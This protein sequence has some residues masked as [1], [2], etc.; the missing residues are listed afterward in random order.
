M[1]RARSSAVCKGRCGRWAR[2]MEKGQW[3]RFRNIGHGFMNDEGM[4]ETLGEVLSLCCSLY[5]V[6][7]ADRTN[8]E[9]G[10]DWTRCCTH[11]FQ[12]APSAV[13]LE[14]EFHPNE[15]QSPLASYTYFL[16]RHDTHNILIRYN[17]PQPHS[18]RHMPRTCPPHQRIFECLLERPMH[19]ITHILN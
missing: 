5:L 8:G 13:T 18:L 2:A 1:V 4:N 12:P 14:M 10:R 6:V 9:K 3:G 11:D 15:A 7:L 16:L 17:M 19:L